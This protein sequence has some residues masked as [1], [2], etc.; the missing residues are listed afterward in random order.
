MSLLY[1]TSL[2]LEANARAC[3]TT[4]S[5][6]NAQISLVLRLPLMQLSVGIGGD[7]KKAATQL[8]Y[9]LSIPSLAKQLHKQY[10]L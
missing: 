10:C 8:V 4:M 6:I 9:I 5:N 2:I 7:Q 1:T 3:Y